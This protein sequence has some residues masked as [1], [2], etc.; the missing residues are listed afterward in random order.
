MD[1]EPYE[2]QIT[3]LSPP[4]LFS[5]AEQLK[6]PLMQIARL[7]ESSK[8]DNSFYEPLKLI[9]IT[10]DSAINLIDS[11][12]L[13]LKLSL[14]NKGLNNEAVSVSA[15]LYDTAEQLHALAESYGVILD[16]NIAGKF[17]PVVA[18]RQA[19]Q[20]ALV[21]LGTSLI[22]ALPASD[23]TNRTLHLASHRSRYGV[24]AGMYAQA[25]QLSH[26]LLMQGRRLQKSSRQPFVGLSH[27]NSAGIYVADSIL[28]AM[29][30]N[31]LASRHHN[32]Y[33]LGT[34]LQSNYQLQLLS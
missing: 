23:G 2:G 16:L 4:L 12:A 32:L 31:L 29:D 6:L 27:T 8:S 22:E 19:L 7:A 24:V 17:G 13:S 34:V 26:S 28:K 15:V 25:K 11:F 1:I 30:L 18:N 10:A 21:S 5:L 3:A 14:N 9:E 33:G 20:A